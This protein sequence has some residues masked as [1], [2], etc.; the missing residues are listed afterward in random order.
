MSGMEILPLLCVAMFLT[1]MVDAIAGGGG[2]IS[3]PVFLMAGLPARTAYGTNKVM[4]LM[5]NI[6]S[7]WRYR[8]N[9]Y[10]DTGA[11]IPLAITVAVGELLGTRVVYLLPEDA[12]QTF[13]SL[14]LPAVAL[15]TLLSKRTFTYDQTAL[16]PGWTRE[17]A[18]LMG[19][20]VGMGFYSGLIG[21]A[22]ATLAMMLLCAVLHYDVR[23]ANGTLKGAFILGGIACLGIYLAQGDVNWLFALPSVLCDMAGNYVGVGLATKKGAKMVRP[24]AL[25]VVCVYAGKTLWGLFS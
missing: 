25:I 9:G 15:F 2:L 1:G 12:L 17:R 13:L 4:A 3:L 5:G 11:A 18:K 6:T 7:A 19:I 22:G 21:A 23:V 10:W 24:V 8:Q 20:G 14:V 16:P